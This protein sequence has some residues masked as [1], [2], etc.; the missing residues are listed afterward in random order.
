MYSKILRNYLMPFYEMLNKKELLR[1]LNE[2]ESHLQWNAEQ[3]AAHQWQEL[4]LLLSHAYNTT[5]FYRKAWQEVGVTDIRDIKNLTDFSTL[6]LITKLDIQQHYAEFVSSKYS[7]NI[8]KSTGG[9]T[10]QPFHF[11][12]NLESNTRREAIMWRGYGWLGA[13]LGEKTLYLW[14]ADIGEKTFLKAIKND[15]Y[16]AFYNRKMLNSFAMNKNNMMEYIDQIYRYKPSAIVSYVNPLYELANFIIEHKIAVYQ[17]KTILTGAEPLYPHQRETIQQAFNCQVN[18]TFGCREFMLMSAECRKN[19]NLHINSDHLVIETVNE[20][21]QSVKGLSGDLAITDLYNYGMPL[22]RYLNGD[23]ATLI[24]TAC[25]CGN[26]L[27][28]MKSVD[29]RKLDIIK[30]PS[31]KIIPGELF[32]HLFKEFTC[33]QRF[34]VKQT[35]LDSLDI[36]IIENTPLDILSREKITSEINK[37]TQGE[38]AINFSI[39]N[40]IALTVSGKHRVTI[41]EV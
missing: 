30:T 18:D 10:G 29:G 5:S 12:Y 38:L 32:P 27:P 2:Y 39:V 8:R 33:I 25:S 14:G 37:Y 16:H 24:E 35:T 7:N 28:I 13:G 40:E 1:H 9:S 22:I 36:L 41:C 19:N 6:P 17:P 15:L 11:E 31:G 3:L 26:P 23:R 4:S 34:Q 20:Q 21:G